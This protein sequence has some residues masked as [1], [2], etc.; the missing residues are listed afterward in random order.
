VDP[1]NDFQARDIVYPEDD[2]ESFQVYYSAAHKFYYVSDQQTSE[3]WVMIQSDSRGPIGTPHTA[4]PNPWAADDTLGR[5]SIEVR[6]MVF[7]GE[8]DGA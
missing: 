3:A 4:F 1:A 2:V 8:V 7:Y 5:E 6:A